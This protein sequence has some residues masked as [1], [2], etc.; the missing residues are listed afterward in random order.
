MF[1]KK[2]RKIE[3]EIDLLKEELNQLKKEV[4]CLKQEFD[5]LTQE[6]RDAFLKEIRVKKDVYNE[7][8]ALIRRER[9]QK[10]GRK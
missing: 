7:I 5:L 1:F 4:S 6:E 3:Y 9:E 10:G 2:A 8:A